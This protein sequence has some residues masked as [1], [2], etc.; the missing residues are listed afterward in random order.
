VQ[1][2]DRV[3][4]CDE[5]AREGLAEVRL[6]DRSGSAP[7]LATHM[8]ERT[9]DARSPGLYLMLSAGATLLVLCL[10]RDPYREPLR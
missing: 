2:T 9:G 1:F 3:D 7:L 10:I 6:T 5:R 4:A 8:V